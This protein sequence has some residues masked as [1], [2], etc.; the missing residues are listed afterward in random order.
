MREWR[1]GIEEVEFT[2]FREQFG[3]LVF[4]TV[5]KAWKYVNYPYRQCCQARKSWCKNLPRW[6]FCG[7]RA[8]IRVAQTSSNYCNFV[9]RCLKTSLFCEYNYI[10]LITTSEVARGQKWKKCD[11][12]I[13][14]YEAAEALEVREK[15][16][17][18]ARFA[19]V[20]IFGFMY[21]GLKI[22]FLLKW[23]HQKGQN[24]STTI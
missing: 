14:T 4:A 11:F 22:V 8:K 16:I 23:S 6:F 3:H 12:V 7:E 5:V 10:Q 2:H 17:F 24:E 19:R 18:I 1:R 20:F 21:L 15:S 9:L 13:F